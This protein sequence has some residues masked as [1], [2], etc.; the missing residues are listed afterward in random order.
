MDMYIKM[1]VIDFH[2]ILWIFL[3]FLF[4]QQ[5]FLHYSWNCCRYEICWYCCSVVDHV[6]SVL[7]LLYTI[8]LIYNYSITFKIDFAVVLKIYHLSSVIHLVNHCHSLP[9]KGAA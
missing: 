4:L 2:T 9:H 5:S 6:N 3:S 7:L 1:K 8:M